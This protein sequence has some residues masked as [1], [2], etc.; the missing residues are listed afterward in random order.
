MKMQLFGHTFA[1]AAQPVQQL[2]SNALEKLIL[3]ILELLR[4]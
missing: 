2:F 3:F 4:P 1:H